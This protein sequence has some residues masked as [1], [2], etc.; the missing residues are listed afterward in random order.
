MGE[1]VVLAS[2]KGGIGK[3]ALSLCIGTSLA[4]QGKSVLLLDLSA[5]MR[6]LDILMGLENRIVFDWADVITGDCALEQ[7]LITTCMPSLFLISAPQYGFVPFDTDSYQALFN[8]LRQRFDY[9]IADTPSG[10]THGYAFLPSGVA[11]QIVLVTSPDDAAMRDAE[12]TRMLLEEKGHTVSWL[13]INRVEPGGIHAGYQHQPNIVRQTLDIPLLGVI[14]EDKHWGAT[15]LQ[16]KWL[17][18]RH[19][20]QLGPATEAVAHVARRL[21]GMERLPK[22]WAVIPSSKEKGLSS[23]FRP[24]YRHLVKEVWL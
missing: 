6:Q 9:V 23:R 18:T 22:E 8:P 11:D 16:R 7:A 4:E 10:L 17:Q 15:I 20:D 24:R 5:G 12:R 2:G 1:T 3:S 13:L 14:P 21:T 19:S